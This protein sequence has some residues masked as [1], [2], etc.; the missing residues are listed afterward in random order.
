[1]SDAP[2]SETPL[3]GTAG[4]PVDAASA[5]WLLMDALDATTPPAS[6]A[7]WEPPALEELDHLWKEYQIS[8]ML[9]RGGMGAV[10][11][12]IDPTLRRPVAIKILPPE[13]S[14]LPGFA[15]RFRR[16]AW[17]LAQ[18]EHPHIVKIYQFGSTSDGH[19]FFVMEYLEGTNLADLL[20][21]Q[22]ANDP[23]RPPFPPGQVLEIACQVCDAL[24]GAHAQGIL[25][26]DIKPANLLMD[27]NGHI[28]LVDFG[29]ARPID[30]TRPESQLTVTHQVIGTRDYMA[31]EL[32]DGQDIDGR[33]DVYAVGVLIYEMLTGELPR[34]VFL[35]PSHRQPLDRRLAEMVDKAMQ[36]DPNRRFA[37][38][39]EM[40]AALETLRL[41]SRGLPQSRRL[42]V[43]AALV[44]AGAAAGTSVHYSRK[45]TRDPAP[46]GAGQAGAAAGMTVPSL[47]KITVAP[48]RPPPAL[49]AGL[50]FEESF[51]YPPGENGMSL[52]PGYGPQE[53]TDSSADISAEGMSYAAPDGA[54]LLTSG[55]AALLDAAEEHS[56][57][58]HI[59]LLQIPN[60]PEKELW[61]SLLAQQT[62]G[63]NGRFFNLSFRAP[64]N[65]YQPYDPDTND[66]EIL[67]IGM[68]SRLS[69]QVWQIWDRGSS[70]EFSKAAV[71]DQPTTRPSFL[72][73][74]M[75]RNAE[76]TKERATLWINPPLASPPAETTGFSFTSHASDLTAWSDLKVLRLGAGQ[77]ELDAP[78]TSW[79]VDEIRIGWTHAAVTPHK[80][81]P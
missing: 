54:V 39:T 59:T 67:A 66:D 63:N 7:G 68:R 12:G 11:L 18:L 27:S 51:D 21:Q 52:A 47:R 65:V 35:P 41:S 22:K 78:G 81:A 26:R 56:I 1:M 50:I 80:K 8:R 53:S 9:G 43:A 19:L 42:G 4:P 6:G 17:A 15:D 58:R 45:S 10:Y 3:P 32:L 25:H 40:H 79:L 70:G 62:A 16:E 74:R 34:G 36:A 33:V 24:T 38:I 64:D 29:L 48:M 5:K 71:S 77:K 44:L 57:V 76:G 14:R 49:G 73:V 69:P 55:R 61:I 28:K 13:L 37:T 20:L 31:P 72:L 46:L 75:D 30:K 2:E 23:G 60:S